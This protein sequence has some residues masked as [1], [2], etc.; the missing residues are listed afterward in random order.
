MKR[1]GARFVSVSAALAVLVTVF[2]LSANEL[3]SDELFREGTE[4][5]AKGAYAGAIERFEALS[6]R[7]F[8][9]PDASYD[10]GLAY[11]GR[12]RAGDARP[13][14]LGRAAAAFEETLLLRPDDVDAD[15]ALDLVRADVARKRSRRAK[16]VETVR[17]TLDRV[18]V[19]LA[20]ERT[21][22]LLALLSSVLFSAGLFLRK[23]DEHSRRVAGR[24]LAPT[25]LLLLVMFLP[26]T[27]SARSLRLST[28]PAVVVVPE[29]F[30]VDENGTALGGKPIPEAH[31]V[32]AG[33][34]RGALIH[35]RWGATE[36]FLPTGSI[37]LLGP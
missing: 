28:R 36:G 30:L 18:V 4:A 21:W 29:V 5:L 34:V 1:A 22:S 14:D 13:G 9:H 26:L 6:D 31:R 3:S 10:R 25:A 32:E 2:P 33:E 20:S 24:I 27:L 7:G 11:V 12:V 8:V 35:V 19:G 16:D 17:P 15:R 37:R 23:S